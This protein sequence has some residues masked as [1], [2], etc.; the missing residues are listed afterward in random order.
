MLSRPKINKPDS[1]RPRLQRELGRLAKDFTHIEPFGSDGTYHAVLKNGHRVLITVNVPGERRDLTAVGGQMEIFRARQTGRSKWLVPMVLWEYTTPHILAQTYLKQPTLA[2]IFCRRAPSG[3]AKKYIVRYLLS[4]FVDQ[5]CVS[6]HFLA[7]PGLDD[8]FIAP[9]KGVGCNNF[10][11]VGWLEPKERR[12]LA[13]LLFAL[14]KGERALAVKIILAGHYRLVYPHHT[15][16]TGLHLTGPPG[17]TIAKEL[18]AILNA[19]EDGNIIIPA[20]LVA[21]AAAWRGL[22]IMINTFDEEADLEGNLLAILQ[23]QLPLIFKLKKDATP[24]EVA[25]LVMS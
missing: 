24:K 22:E 11:A 6:G 17:N 25:A 2:D 10:L 8:F 9:G 5:L 21:A 18:Q 19:G 12:L 15:H 20:S 23:G 3:A 13:A 7:H 4:W 16:K 14:L 1:I